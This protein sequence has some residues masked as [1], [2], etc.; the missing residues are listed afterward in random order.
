MTSPNAQPVPINVV[1]SSIFGLYPKISVERTYNMFESDAWLVNYPGF[2]RRTAPGVPGVGR[3]FYRTIDGDRC[4][5]VVGST[6]YILDQNLGWTPIDNELDTTTGF[7]S[8]AENINGQIAI[9][10][11]VRLWIYHPSAGNS[12]TA[13]S[14]TFTPNYVT[15]HNS[16]FLIAT[17]PNSTNPQQWVAAIRASDTTISIPTA[18]V[19]ALQTKADS[20]IAV[21][22]IPGK[23]NNVL[24]LGEVVAEVWSQVGTAVPYTRI[25]SFNID[26]GC[27][28]VAT[29][30][31]SEEFVC[32]LAQNEHS[33]PIILFTNG[34]Q[35]QQISSDGISHLLQT[36]KHP[37]KSSAFFFKQDGHLFY[38]LTFFDD[39]DNITLFYD[40]T[41]Q[42][43][44]DATDQNY[45]YHPAA[46]VVYFQHKIYFLS[47]R[48][49][50]VYEMGPQFV[51]YN[52]NIDEFEDGDVIPRIRTCK[53]IRK[54]DTSIF[55]ASRLS[56]WIEQGVND[57]F[58]GEAE[59]A[60]ICFGRLITEDDNPI[61]T[62]DGNYMLVENG[63]CTDNRPIDF[64]IDT[65]ITE[66]GNP[67]IGE[68]GETMLAQQG[69][70][71]YLVDRTLGPRVDL[72]FSKNGNQSFGTVVS[73]YINAQGIYRNQMTWQ[74]FG[75][76]NELTLQFRFW[77]LQRFVV[78]NAVLETY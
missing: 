50:Y 19:F 66:D 6:A 36:I 53:S 60:V 10:D 44:Y 51:T 49:N 34:G 15:Y 27:V 37:D 55:R 22:R 74:Q 35:I 28:S 7:V 70:C 25:Q 17:G 62:E 77:G 46:Q 39:E 26:Y 75:Q 72:N 38:Q 67:I 32:W 2:Q 43:F 21:V 47:L 30:A 1:G 63:Y 12:L 56:L 3:G 69:Y 18:N 73:R 11:G 64:C 71:V 48:D 13:Q 52:Y 42:K 68:N 76:A 40:F 65:L 24:V 20:A 29:V 5:A 58:L 4:F 16:F 78:Q 23:G 14:L 31:Q 33:S 9:C 41:T 61:I 45:N 59:A 57:F 54:E 8:I